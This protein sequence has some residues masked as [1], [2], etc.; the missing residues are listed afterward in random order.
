M[1]KPSIIGVSGRYSSVANSARS[2]WAKSTGVVCVW[3]P[4]IEEKNR[5]IKN[6]SILDVTFPH[7]IICTAKIQLASSP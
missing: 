5:L 4:K 3:N 2:P 7:D 1:T 6:N